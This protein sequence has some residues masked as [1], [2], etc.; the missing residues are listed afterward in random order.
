M[1]PLE[2]ALGF[3]SRG[4]YVFPILPLGVGYKDKHGNV[5]VSDGKHPAVSFPTWATRSEAKIRKRWARGDYNVGIFT[6]RFGDDEALVVVDVDDKKGKS[7]SSTLVSLELQ[8]LDVPITLE[9]STPSGG[10]HLIYR[11]P[12]ALKQGTDVLGSGLDIRSK[13]GYIVAPGS[14]IDGKPYLQINGH[15]N[16]EL[17]PEWLVAKLGVSKP[18]TI[19][20]DTPSKA[21]PAR[22]EERAKAYLAAAPLAVEGESGDQATFKVAA[23]LKDL[24]CTRD[25]ALWLMDAH[26]NE[27]CSPPWGL[28]Q[29]M[30]KVS[31]A[32]DYGRDP[33]GVAAPEAVFDAEDD[34]PGEDEP[35]DTH[36]IDKLNKEY[37]F[38]KRG[39]FILQE[40]TDEKGRYTT[41]HL[42][43]DAFHAW[44][45]NQPL[46]IGEKCKS[47]SKWWMESSRRRQY[48]GVVF[49]PQQNPGPRW[50]NLWQ[51]FAT[52]PATCPASHKAL[53]MFLE[54][55][56]KNICGG[57]PKLCHW[58][59]G[60]FAHMIQ[61]PWEK[62]LVALVF[63]GRKGTGKNALVERVGAL[64][65]PHFLVADSDRY[66]LSNFNSHFETNL[67]FVLDEATW[68]GD[69][70]AEGRLKGLITGAKHNIERKGQEPY[71]VDNL[72]RVA[73]LGN[74][75]WMVPATH[76]ERRFAVFNLGEGRMQ[77]RAFFQEMREGMEAGGYQH[78]LRYLQDF[79][80]SS[81]DVNDAP[82]TQ[83]LVEQKVASLEFVPQWWMDCLTEGHMVGGD[84]GGEWPEEI[85]TNRIY[86]AFIR[87]A[88]EKNIHRTRLPGLKSFGRQITSLAPHFTKKKV[89]KRAA[90]G[91]TTYVR[92]NPGLDLLRQDMERYLGGKVEWD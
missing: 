54:H 77:D 71:T 50:F 19:Q 75:E 56:L 58:L 60:W 15:S 74:E 46:R 33:Q 48:E 17:A 63:R 57:D 72:T 84:F 3:A 80:L 26:W 7:G 13:G 47:I 51:G 61:R 87:W 5:Q 45:A 2:S 92:H 79:D 86:A 40:T 16:P 89:A 28:D 78:L 21:D 49:M 64:L 83:A 6:G 1:T 23:R 4:F 35:A 81:V 37:A 43:V 38:I 27:R 36:P 52:Q 82:V 18:R 88:K 42:G 85:P 24:G 22:A 31:N 14:E 91:D 65:G 12:K 53:D 55:A 76:D 30:E 29:L 39:A 11:T 90:E 10:K 66:L 9:H 67:F 8:G 73:I 20:A 32:F 69:K 59:L 70:K 41:C 34:E 68:A 44:H 25:Q 62:P